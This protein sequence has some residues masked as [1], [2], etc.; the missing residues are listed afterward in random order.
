M[1]THPHLHRGV[2]T[3]MVGHCSLNNYL[4]DMLALL[5]FPLPLLAIMLQWAV[6]SSCGLVNFTQALL[7][8]IQQPF[9]RLFLEPT[10]LLCLTATTTH[11]L[12]ASV[13]SAAGDDIKTRTR[14][15]PASCRPHFARCRFNTFFSTHQDAIVSTRNQERFFSLPNSPYKRKEERTNASS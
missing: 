13:A 12:A 2:R 6:D 10:D 3:L 9:L 5:L 14:N 7:L 1:Q 4:S 8:H 11:S 15:R